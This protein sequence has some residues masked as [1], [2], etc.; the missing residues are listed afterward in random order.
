MKRSRRRIRPS[1][2]YA[3]NAHGR[4]ADGMGVRCGGAVQQNPAPDLFP[5]VPATTGSSAPVS[6]VRGSAGR[7]AGLFL[8]AGACCQ[9]YD[10]NRHET[11]D[12][13]EKNDDRRWPHHREEPGLVS[14]ESRDAEDR[15]YY[16]GHR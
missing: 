1:I 6:A 12:Q 16:R 8:H 2:R 15:G 10:S 13:L 9:D 14:E 7:A 11:F 3:P 5:L 4:R